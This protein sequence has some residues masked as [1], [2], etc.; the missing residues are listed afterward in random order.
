M[1]R[2]LALAV[3]LSLALAAPV[4]AA[5]PETY[6]AYRIRVARGEDHYRLDPGLT[7]LAEKRAREVGEAVAAA[8]VVLPLTSY[9]R[10][11][12]EVPCGWGEVLGWVG[13]DSPTDGI[14]WIMA[15]WRNSPGHWTVISGTWARYGVG[16][17]FRDG[18]WYLAVVFSR[19]RLA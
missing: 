4:S 16:A 2:G 11:L 13:L 15:A 12:V 19:C 14:R 10:P 7:R 9:H 17:Y 6:L 18:R 8:T 5:S 1:R 3:L